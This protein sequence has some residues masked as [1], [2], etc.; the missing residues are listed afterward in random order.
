MGK[1]SNPY[2]AFV[3]IVLCGVKFV[4]NGENP[5]SVAK[6][7]AEW[8]ILAFDIA[9]PQMEKIHRKSSLWNTHLLTTYR[10]DIE[11]I[12]QIGKVLVPITEVCDVLLLLQCSYIVYVCLSIFM[13]NP[14][15]RCANPLSKKSQQN[16]GDTSCYTVTLLLF[17]RKRY[18]YTL[19]AIMYIFLWYDEGNARFAEKTKNHCP[20]EKKFPIS[21]VSLLTWA[22]KRK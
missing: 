6:S 12:L 11:I 1:S 16:E 5:F 3:A 19:A 21:K 17:P 22:K 4:V 20:R 18:V 7:A 2:A 9:D 8:K 13:T 14:F 10:P 15:T